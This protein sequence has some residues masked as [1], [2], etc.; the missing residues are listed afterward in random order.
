MTSA[1]RKL[2]GVLIFFGLF[3]LVWKFVAFNPEPLQLRIFNYRT[4]EM[5]A[6]L[7]SVFIFVAGILLSTFLFFSAVVG[8][9]L[10]KRRLA[11]EN[12]SL[13]RLLNE[14]LE[15]AKKRLG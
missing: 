8:S 10:E 11:R 13:Q 1:F 7:L 6:G 12:E 15:A 2:A 9:R 14:H 3:W 5:S 4:V